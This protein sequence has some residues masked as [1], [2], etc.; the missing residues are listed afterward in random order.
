MILW[1]KQKIILYFKIKCYAYILLQ[2]K[3][4]KSIFKQNGHNVSICL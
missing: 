3:Q 1:F 4:K 2:K